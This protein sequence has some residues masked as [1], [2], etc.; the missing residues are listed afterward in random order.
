MLNAY[1][2]E[3][4]SRYRHGETAHYQCRHLLGLFGNE[5][6]TCLDGNWTDP[7]ECKDSSG[8]CGRPPAI[9]NG[10]IISNPLPVYAP[11]SS[12]EYQCQAYYVLDGNKRITCSNGEWSEP[13]KCLGKSFSILMGP[14]TSV[15][16]MPCL[17][18]PT[19]DCAS[20]VDHQIAMVWGYNVW[21]ILEQQQQ[22]TIICLYCNVFSQHHLCPLLPLPLNHPF[23]GSLM[24]AL[25]RII[26]IVNVDFN[27]QGS[28]VPQSTH[29]SITDSLQWV[30]ATRW[31]FNAVVCRRVWG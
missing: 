20:S 16:W 7:P 27:I 28:H 21:K 31:I 17:P 2:P 15:E 19:E 30:T 29:F 22:E 13:P 11:G 8:K 18:L 25:Q 14:G 10:D 1:V 3:E 6:V 23:K 9:D 12:V 4:K 5:V 24:E 26:D